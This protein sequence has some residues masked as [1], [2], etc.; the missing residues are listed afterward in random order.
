M[1]ESMEGLKKDIDRIKDALESIL[2]TM[3]IENRVLSIIVDN[4]AKEERNAKED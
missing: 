4:L 1:N 3:E 2:I